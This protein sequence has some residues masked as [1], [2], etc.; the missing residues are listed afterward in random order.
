MAGTVA[1]T[2]AAAAAG[3]WTWTVAG[4]VPAGISQ[5]RPPTRDDPLN[6]ARGPVGRPVAGPVSGATWPRSHRHGTRPAIRVRRS[7]SDLR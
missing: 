4:T 1:G 3:T 6:R 5:Y 2:V 7:G